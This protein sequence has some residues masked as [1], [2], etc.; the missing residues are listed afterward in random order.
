MIEIPDASACLFV[1]SKVS[2]AWIVMDVTM[3]RRPR[4]WLAWFHQAHVGECKQPY[5][6]E[7]VGG[8]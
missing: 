3:V 6:E 1:Q 8:C 4:F 2:E 7:A 5:L